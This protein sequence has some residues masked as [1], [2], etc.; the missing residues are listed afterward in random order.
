MFKI[1]KRRGKIKYERREKDIDPDEILLD[2]SNLPNFDVHQFEGRLEKPISIRSIFI[3][4]F[5][6]LA[7]ISIFVCKIWIFQVKDA[8]IY[9]QKSENNRL[10]HTLIFAKRGIIYDKNN[11]KLAWNGENPDES[12]FDFRK[13]I[14]L[15]GFAHVLGYVKYPA[16]DNSGFYYTEVYSGKDGVEKFF[17]SNL[18]GEN[19]LQLVEVN[20]LGSVQSESVIRPPQDGQDIKLS[21]D[22]GLQAKIYS[23]ISGLAKQVGFTGGAGVIMDVKTGEVLSLTSYPEYNPQILTDGSDTKTIQNYLTD[24]NKSFLDRVIDGLYTPGSIVKPYMAIAAQSEKVIDQYQNIL[25]TGS[26]SLPNPYDPNNPSVFKDWR[27][28]G[29]VDMRKAL[30]V[31]SDVYFYEVGG[32][33]QDQK[34]LGIANIDKYMKMFGLGSPITSPFFKGVAGTIPTPEWKAA[35]FNGEDWRIG[36]T[37]HTS[38]GQYG[39]QVSPIQMVRAVASIANSGTLI[40]PSILLGGNPNATKDGINLNLDSKYFQVV[41]EGMHDGVTK[42]YGVA[43]G[44]NSTQY[45][46]AAKTG[47]AELGAYKQFVNSWITGFFPYENPKYAFAILMEKGPVTNTMGGV[48]VMRQVMDWIAANRPEYVK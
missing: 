7:I 15:D 41:R 44:L 46:I 33:F 6:F 38:I 16:K 12:G 40:E 24:K 28:Q 30:A 48:Y 1:G 2:S 3:L 27:A 36:D 23:T 4:G 18:A 19:G 47:T 17:D 20:A 11:I 9:T 42:D 5:V 43:K 13:Y 34:G 31:S 14:S 25:S 21:I 10:N 32:G 35:N 39:F 26:I 22:S 29:Y 45:T 8:S 37:Y